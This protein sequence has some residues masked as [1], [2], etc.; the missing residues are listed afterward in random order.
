MWRIVTS[1]L[2]LSY[3][4]KNFWRENSVR[5]Q[6]TA[7]KGTLCFCYQLS[8][9]HCKV[10]TVFWVQY[11]AHSGKFCFYYHLTAQ[12]SDVR[13]VLEWIMW[14]IDETSVLLSLNRTNL[15]RE[16][17]VRVYYVA[18]SG[19]FFFCYHLRAQF[20]DLTSVLGCKFWRIKEHS[21]YVIHIRAQLCNV[22]TVLE[23]TLWPI[24][25][26]SAYIII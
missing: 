19:R 13:T 9:Q 11:V 24:E 2:L 20:C 3:N 6:Y 17:G 23:C 18:H 25:E 12:I 4:S 8:A 14:P 10:R 16:N 22:K 21:A 15:W 26:A 5:V 1:V 7:H